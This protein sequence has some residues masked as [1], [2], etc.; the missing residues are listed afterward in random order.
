[1]LPMRY[2]P[3]QV[4]LPEVHPVHIGHI[5]VGFAAKRVAPRTSLATLVVAAYFLDL[6]WP[7]TLWLEHHGAHAGPGDPAFCPVDLGPYFHSLF[8]ALVWGAVLALAY[9]ART[10]YATGAVVVGL[11]VLSHW[12]LDFVAHD[13]DLWLAP[14]LAMRVGLGLGDSSRA[15]AI[16]EGALVIAGLALYLRTMRAKS[17]VGHVSLWS[18]VGVLALRFFGHSVWHRY[19]LPFA[20]ETP[21]VFPFAVLV[22]MVWLILVDR[23]RTLRTAPEALTTP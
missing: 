1:M 13:P 8:M 16:S 11:A 22:L 14:G 5:G 10:R 17:W 20:V 4:V 23:S 19:D 3:P 12:V 15:L 6:Q 9:R 2:T 7:L 18:M 21:R